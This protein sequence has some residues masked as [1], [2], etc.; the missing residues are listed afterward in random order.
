MLART[1]LAGYRDFLPKASQRR[2]CASPACKPCRPAVRSP[3]E[4]GGTGCAS[5]S[6]CFNGA[7][8]EGERRVS[9]SARRCRRPLIDW[10]GPM[11]YPALQSRCST[12]SCRRA[13]NGTGRAISSTRSPTRR[14]TPISRTPPSAERNLAHAPLPDRRRGPSRRQG[15]RRRGARATPDGQWSSSA[16]IPSPK[17]AEAIRRWA[18]GLLG[19]VHPFNLAGGYPIS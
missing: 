1:I 4:H 10:A 19:A 5:P 8:V 13:C 9:R 11:P 14:S 18:R 6:C 7:E 17:N 16:S 15:G 3:K 12:G 2:R